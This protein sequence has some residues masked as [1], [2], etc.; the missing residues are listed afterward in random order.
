MN[1]E[2][3][4]KVVIITG[5]AASI[6]LSISK[7]LIEA[8]AKV[9]IAARNNEAGETAVKY[10][11]DNCKF[12]QTDIG[13]DEQLDILINKTVT[14]YGKIDILINNA[15]SYGDEGSATN[16]ETWLETLNINVVSAAILGE[17]LRPYLKESRGNIVNIGSISG[18]TAHVGRWAYP[19]AKAAMEHLSSSQA[20]DYSEDGIRVNHL[21]LGHIWSAPFNGLTENNQE[22]ANKTTAAYNLVGRVANPEEVANTV[23]F[24][25]SSKAS[26]ITG[27]KLNVDGGYSILGPERKDPLMRLLSEG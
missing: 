26:Y 16:R 4:G 15:C 20:L 8:G 5:G 13:K 12:F 27:A 1:V 18:T 6:G 9:V 23:V 24:I 25:A 14:M 19:V 3:E 10:L 22:H 17:K 2:L 21:R 11:G 7:A